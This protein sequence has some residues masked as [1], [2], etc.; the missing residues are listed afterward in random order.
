MT[1]QV[2]NNTTKKTLIIREKNP[3]TGRKETVERQFTEVEALK[4][5]QSMIGIQIRKTQSVF[6]K[7]MDED[8]LQQEYSMVVVNAFR[9]YRIE[10]N[11]N[12][13]SLVIKSFFNH[14]CKMCYR[15]K[16]NRPNQ[17]MTVS[18]EEPSL[19]GDGTL[20]DSVLKNEE[21]M[22]SKERNQVEFML[23]LQQFIGT[24]KCKFENQ[25]LHL[26]RL[27]AVV[28]LLTLGLSN[29]EIQNLIAAYSQRKNLKDLEI[30]NSEYVLHQP[31][32]KIFR[33]R[34]R[35]DSHRFCELIDSNTV[36]FYNG[37]Y[38]FPISELSVYG[39]MEMM[40]HLGITE[41]IESMQNLRSIGE[42]IRR[43]RDKFETVADEWSPGSTKV[44][45]RTARKLKPKAI[46]VLETV[47]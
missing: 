21:L 33:V 13:E 44:F 8:D 29:R 39:E 9:A 3:L 47:S 5:S 46:Q 42:L 17:I 19:S 37:S 24:Q 2:L 1:K 25:K 36:S 20:G 10:T 18:L 28:Q 7:L 11:C 30:L 6:A 4:Y 12:F 15:T 41:L 34:N 23:L 32:K 16:I 27:E 22:A 26:Q 43:V 14:F 38:V 40:D 35:K 31:S 45:S